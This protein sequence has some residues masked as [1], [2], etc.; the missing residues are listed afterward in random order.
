MFW[1]SVGHPGALNLPVFL[2]GPWLTAT[3]EIPRQ[4][5]LDF[6]ILRSHFQPQRLILVNWKHASVTREGTWLLRVL[7]LASTQ[8]W[9]P[10]VYNQSKCVPCVLMWWQEIRWQTHVKKTSFLRSSNKIKWLEQ[11]HPQVQCKSG[12]AWERQKKRDKQQVQ[13]GIGKLAY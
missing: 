1:P 5:P 8:R 4:S 11:N 7:I 10:Q 3:L 12:I 2:Q 6:C 13:Q 9:T